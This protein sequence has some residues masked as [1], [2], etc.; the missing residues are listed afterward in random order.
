VGVIV[1]GGG[2]AA[3]AAEIL[4]ILIAAGIWATFGGIIALVICLGGSVNVQ[5]NY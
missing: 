1:S 2:L 3:V 5:M 4:G